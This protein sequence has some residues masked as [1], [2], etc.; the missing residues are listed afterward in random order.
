MRRRRLKRLWKTLGGLRARKRLRRDELLMALG[1]ARKEAGRAWGLV[2]IK[3]PRPRQDVNEQTFSFS[4]DKGRLRRVRRREGRYLLR[5]NLK[6]A[7]PETVWEHYL[8]L[9]RVEQ[10]FKD[11]KGDLRVRP[12]WHQDEQR[13]EAHIFVSF[14]AYC[15]H[16]TLRN[17]A[18]GMAGGLT[19]AAILEKLAAIQMI[20]VEL[21][22]TDGRRILLSR[23]T[24][25]ERGLALLLER[26]KLCLPSQPRPRVLADGQVEV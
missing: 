26:L 5:S 15:L 14:L 8:L 4:L 23:Y 16:T 11:L 7:A 1:A 18:R 25:P 21:P 20:D 10:A 13:I 24:Q 12:I 3:T 19:P 22:T 2:R 6:Q 17:L 9:T